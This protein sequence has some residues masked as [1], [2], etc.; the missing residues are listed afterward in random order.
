MNDDDRIDDALRTDHPPPPSHFFR[1]AVMRR[2]HAEVETPALAF[3]WRIVLVALVL[4]ALAGWF[5]ETPIPAVGMR[6]AIVVIVV[7][8]L[9]LR[10]VDEF[11]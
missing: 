8:A 9:G 7:T 2:I 5:V 4:G 11:V 1:H 10:L 3:P 6:E